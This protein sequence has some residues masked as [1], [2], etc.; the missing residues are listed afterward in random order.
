MTHEAAEIAKLAERVEAAAEG[1]SRMLDS[2]VHVAIHGFPE[3]AYHSKNVMRSRGSPALDRMKWLAGWGVLSY[4]ASLDAAMSLIPEADEA[5]G[6]R[7]RLEAYVTNGVLAEHVRASA[8]VPGAP[9]V[10]AATPALAL[11][12]AAL[13]ARAILSEKVEQPNG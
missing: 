1:G 3:G 12:A 11:T 10:Y 6:E 13:R 8:W 9:R 5:S 4:T 2:E 7:F